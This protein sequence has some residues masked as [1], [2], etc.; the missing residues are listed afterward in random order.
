MDSGFT[1]AVKTA[2]P[3]TYPPAL[4]YFKRESFPE[5]AANTFFSITAKGDNERG[6]AG[7]SYTTT[8]VTMSDFDMS[9]VYSDVITDLAVKVPTS[10]GDPETLNCVAF[11][12]SDHDGAGSG[13]VTYSNLFNNKTIEESPKVFID[14]AGSGISVKEVG[15]LIYLSTETGGGDG[16]AVIALTGDATSNPDSLL[17]GRDGSVGSDWNFK[18]IL[19]APYETSGSQTTAAVVNAAGAAAY[20]RVRANAT[21]SATY[22]IRR[23]SVA[24]YDSVKG[25]GHGALRRASGSHFIA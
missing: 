1:T 14:E 17:Y 22:G 16:I 9:R 12:I 7:N 4:N 3:T 5:V 11:N 21:T 10:S 25:A 24:T 23:M 19:F 8:A 20:D 15:S 2:N 6:D 13:N 18:E